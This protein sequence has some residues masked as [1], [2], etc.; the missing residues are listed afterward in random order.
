M[1]ESETSDTSDGTLAI[2]L[3]SIGL[4]IR[5]DDDSGEET[6]D[7]MVSKPD[8]TS[9]TAQNATASVNNLATGFASSSSSLKGKQSVSKEGSLVTSR[10]ARPSNMQIPGTNNLKAKTSQKVD[11]AG[12]SKK[13]NA[14]S[15]PRPKDEE[16][17]QSLEDQMPNLM[18]KGS[19]GNASR[20]SIKPYLKHWK[21]NVKSKAEP[22]NSRSK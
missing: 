20:G 6:D 5:V 11:R 8:P 18:G 22:S 16:E 1:E 14:G 4:M 3:V 15:K 9:D 17:E 13:S 21:N 7:E 12:S 19:K 10:P 2:H